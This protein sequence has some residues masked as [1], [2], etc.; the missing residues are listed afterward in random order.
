MLTKVEHFKLII[1]LSRQ[2]SNNNTWYNMLHVASPTKQLYMILRAI[3]CYTYKATLHD[4]TCYILLHLQSNFKWYYVL[5]IATPTKQL[6]M[7]LRA[8]YCYTYMILHTR[9]KPLPAALWRVGS[10]IARLLDL[11]RDIASVRMS[12][13]SRNPKLSTWMCSNQYRSVNL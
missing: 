9:S 11:S 6:Y 10:N 8:I 2:Y 1:M 5:Y 7:I 4:T 3:Y 13:Y 12:L